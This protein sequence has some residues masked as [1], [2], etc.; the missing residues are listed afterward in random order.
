MCVTVRATAPTGEMCRPHST[1]EARIQMDSRPLASDRLVEA[2]P[3]QSGRLPPGRA[4]DFRR[5]LVAALR[6]ITQPTVNRDARLVPGGIQ[7]R[8]RALRTLELVLLAAAPVAVFFGLRVR[9]MTVPVMIDPYFY[10]AY[11]Q[12]GPELIARYG[13][14]N[15]Y[16]VR[17]GFILPARVS[18]LLFGAVPGFYV[19]RYV[20]ALLASIPAYLLFKRLHSSP[21]GW[22]AAVLTLTSPVLLT[23]WGTD[24]PDAGAVSYLLAGTACL[25]MPAPTSR[26]RAAW[27]AASGMLLALA[28]HCQVVAGITV[29]AAVVAYLV[30]FGRCAPRT[31]LVHLALLLGAALTTTLVMVLGS[32]LMLGTG[33][34]FRPT[35]HAMLRYREPRSIGFFH[36]ST[37]KWL[38]YDPYLLVPPAVCISWL[39]VRWRAVDRRLEEVALAMATGLAFLGH[40]V[41]QFIGQNWTLEYFLYTS[42]LFSTTCLL[43]AALLVAVSRPLLTR[44]TLCWLPVA[45]AVLVPLALRPFRSL[46]QVDFR[47]ALGLVVAI[48]VIALIARLISRIALGSALSVAG[49][50]TLVMTLITGM[51]LLRPLLPGQVPYFTPDYGTVIFGDGRLPLEQ[52]TVSSQLHV[53]LPP[54]EDGDLMMWWGTNTSDTINEAAA[55]YLWLNNSLP[56]TLPQLDDAEAQMLASRHPRWLVLLGLDGRDFQAASEQLRRRGFHVSS[57]E[58]RVISSGQVTLH[59]KVL[60]LDASAGP[61]PATTA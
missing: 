4:I 17:V 43:L 53:L 42:M 12:H 48:A 18:Y 20:L 56:N 49:L 40:T 35:W 25:L 6:E 32:W 45:L 11:V 9:A 5:L 22:L 8:S 16:W 7:F 15:Y 54:L 13:T 44:G 55:Q 41:M 14:G 19:F 24:Y 58:E 60:E 51:P 10:T 33:D 50:I 34:I 61:V 23:A 46:L 2:Q 31:M 29:G 57:S 21:A 1:A 27:V 36:S 39:V 28:I 3:D 52:Y 38:K 26:R 47:A 30:V 59:F 37:W